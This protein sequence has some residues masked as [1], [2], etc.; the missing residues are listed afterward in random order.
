M[1]CHITPAPPRTRPATVTG[2][3][4]RIQVGRS[5]S[6][7]CLIQL[8]YTPDNPRAHVVLAGKGI[9]FDTGTDHH[10]VPGI[11]TPAALRRSGASPSTPAEP[12]ERG[13]RPGQGPWTPH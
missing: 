11:F 9:T 7:P 10:H 2:V 5:G 3:C 1:S 13:D 6:P 8:S 12:A 4:T